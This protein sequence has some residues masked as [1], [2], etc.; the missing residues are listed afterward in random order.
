MKRLLYL[1]FLPLFFLFF[2]QVSHAQSTEPDILTSMLSV[3]RTE[4]PADGVQTAIVTVIVR[5]DQGMP[6]SGKVVTPHVTPVGS[7]IVE[8]FIATSDSLGVTRFT[9]RSS[10]IGPSWI[11]AFVENHTISSQTA[12]QFTKPVCPLFGYGQLIKLVDDGNLETQADSSVY[13]Y[14]PDCKRHAFPNSRIYFTWFKDFSN[15]KLVTPS[16]LAAIPLGKNVTYR[17]GIRLVKFPSVPK[18][19]TVSRG[20]ILRW[21]ASESVAA[22]LY[23]TDWNTKVHD[24]SEA[25]FSDY[26]FGDDIISVGQY[27]L[28][29]ELANVTH[30]EDN[31]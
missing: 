3:N 9:I 20:G 18:V 21:I 29:N 5:N 30:I 13:Y 8:P 19:Y 10:K 27:Q 26:K 12:F 25:F 17:P 6:L 22:K 15:I 7:V 31:F 14:G 1:S 4:V 24:L 16:E 2:T 11:A 28:N 23:G